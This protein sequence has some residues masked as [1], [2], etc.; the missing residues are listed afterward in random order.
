[1]SYLD[2]PVGRNDSSVSILT[3]SMTQ[4][5]LHVSGVNNSFQSKRKFL[6]FYFLRLWKTLKQNS[7]RLLLSLQRFVVIFF[8]FQKSILT[9]FRHGQK[10]LKKLE[11]QLLCS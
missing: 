8:N 7:M 3:L 4:H 6:E 5:S 10:P 9:I 2:I 11:I 1:M